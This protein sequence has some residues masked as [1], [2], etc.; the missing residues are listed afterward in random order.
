MRRFL[1]KTPKE[2]SNDHK[3]TYPWSCESHHNQLG[4]GRISHLE[5]GGNQ[6]SSNTQNE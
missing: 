1:P 2:K 4:P 5:V 3:M 6:G